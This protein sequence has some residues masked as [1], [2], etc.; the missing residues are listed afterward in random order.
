MSRVVKCSKEELVY[1]DP[2]MG[3]LSDGMWENSPRME[4]YWICNS[5]VDDGIEME[6]FSKL[7]GRR[8]YSNPLY[9]MSDIEVK[10]WFADKLKLVVKEWLKDNGYGNEGWSRFN[11][12]EVDYLRDGQTV[13]GAYKAYDSL[14]GRED[15]SGKQI[16]VRVTK[17][18]SMLE[19]DDI[20]DKKRIVKVIP[21]MTRLD[22]IVTVIYETDEVQRFSTT[23]LVDVIQIKTID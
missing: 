22:G 3:Q 19:V 16:K 17:K 8:T 14:K 5:L 15:K 18:A 23:T 13:A 12:D 1:L 2:V 21:P 9:D 6:P 10:N 7:Y 11:N 20:I 4:P